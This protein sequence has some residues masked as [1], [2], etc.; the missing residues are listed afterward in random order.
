MST[1]QKLD[2]L[3]GMSALDRISLMHDTLALAEEDIKNKQQLDA[4]SVLS[5]IKTARTRIRELESCLIAE[6]N[7]E[8][9]RRAIL[10]MHLDW[11]KKMAAAYKEHPPQPANALAYIAAAASGAIIVTLID[12]TIKIIGA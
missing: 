4:G 11:E 6:Q 5:F 2:P 8:A 3:E 7:T 12:V 10:E 9:Q 1:T